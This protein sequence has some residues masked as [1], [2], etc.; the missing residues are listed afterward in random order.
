MWNPFAPKPAPAPIETV[1]L[2]YHTSVVNALKEQS[3]MIEKVGNTYKRERDAARRDADHA[4]GILRAISALETPGS[5]HIG[6]KM[7]AKAREGLPEFAGE[8]E[9]A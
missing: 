6:R 4:R 1:T 7:A 5:A 2:A 9:A 3:L 8:R